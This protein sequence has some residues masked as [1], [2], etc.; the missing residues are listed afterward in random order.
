MNIGSNFNPFSNGFLGAQFMGDE[1]DEMMDDV[2]TNVGNTKGNLSM[3]NYVND[4]SS[5]SESCITGN[6]GKT[7]C[8]KSNGSINSSIVNGNG[9][10]TVVEMVNGKPTTKKYIVKNYKFIPVKQAKLV[11]LQNLKPVVK[12]MDTFST[13]ETINGNGKGFTMSGKDLTG[14]GEYKIAEQEHTISDG[15]PKGGDID[16]RKMA[17]PKNFNAVSAMSKYFKPETSDPKLM[18]LII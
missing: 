1:F 11:E 2:M 15:K 4:S 10:A 9:S 3:S 14:S 6:D 7:N 17:T 8:L 12:R 18:L 16:Q 13:H 5:M